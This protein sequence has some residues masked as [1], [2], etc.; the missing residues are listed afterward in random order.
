[1]FEESGGEIHCRTDE[2]NRAS[3]RRADD[4][5]RDLSDIETETRLND[6]PVCSFAMQRVPSAWPTPPGLR[7]LSTQSR[8]GRRR[9]RNL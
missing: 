7:A 1:M 2:R 5:N 4:A 3:Q 6:M 9:L 8:A